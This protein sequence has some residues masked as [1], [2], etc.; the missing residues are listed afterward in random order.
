MR[1]CPGQ[2]SVPVVF[3]ASYH[4]CG[5]AVGSQHRRRPCLEPLHDFQKVRVL[6]FPGT[7]FH[8]SKLGV[9]FLKVAQALGSEKSDSLFRG[10]LIQDVA[11]VLL[12][13]LFTRDT[14]LCGF[15]IDV[16]QLFVSE[17]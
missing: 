3:L 17:M 9:R 10:I 7:R 2:L 6:P 5:I 4:Q 12:K 14:K 16:S 15:G 13:K 1:Q 11:E 8:N